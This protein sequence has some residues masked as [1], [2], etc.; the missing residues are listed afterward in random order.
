LAESS[1]SPTE[2]IDV[3]T[4]KAWIQNVITLLRSKRRSDFRPALVASRSPGPVSNL[5]ARPGGGGSCDEETGKCYEDPGSGGGGGDPGGGGGGTGDPY[6]GV[7]YQDIPDPTPTG[8]PSVDT[9]TQSWTDTVRADINTDLA[10]FSTNYRWR[11]DII[12]AECDSYKQ[13]CKENCGDKNTAWNSLCGIGTGILLMG[14]P[15]GII[16]AA[17]FGPACV[18][19][20][21]AAVTSCKSNCENICSHY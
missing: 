21:Y 3:E 8:D 17:I 10:S 6:A 18:G 19:I 7:P 12:G 11:P 4:R 20:S 2:Q 16:A 5:A 13:S 14:G 15:P 1:L 9:L